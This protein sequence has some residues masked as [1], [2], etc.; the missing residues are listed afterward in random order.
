MR[1]VITEDGDVLYGDIWLTGEQGA[2]ITEDTEDPPPDSRVV[3]ID[4]VGDPLFKRYLCNETVTQ[5]GGGDIDLFGTKSYLKTI[6]GIPPD[7]HGNFTITV[8][9]NEADGPIV[10]IYP[11][12]E[13]RALKIEV[14]G[15]RSGNID[16]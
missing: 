10:R 15:N 4:L 16:V 6:N 2:V 7:E 3:R 8:G 5:I 12:Y 13:T 14:V 11:D 1:G 9:S